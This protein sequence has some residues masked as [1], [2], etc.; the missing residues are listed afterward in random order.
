M[1]VSCKALVSVVLGLV[2]AIILIGAGAAISLVL[3]AA[4]LFCIDCSHG[5]DGINEFI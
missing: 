5:G 3:A 4:A 1:D 2:F